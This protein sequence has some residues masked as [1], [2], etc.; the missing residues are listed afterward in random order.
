M[1]SLVQRHA[2]QASELGIRCAS[3]RL[4]SPA[5]LILL[6]DEWVTSSG[7]VSLSAGWVLGLGSHLGDHDVAVGEDGDE[8]DGDDSGDNGD[9]EEE[10]M[11]MKMKVRMRGVMMRRMLVMVV[12][13]KYRLD[14]LIVQSKCG[15]SG[16]TLLNVP[17]LQ[18]APG[19]V[20]SGVVS[21]H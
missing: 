1:S 10:V 16:K 19:S 2:V 17:V 11:M 20:V 7:S 5:L 12:P 3:F 14:G 21:V 4:S 13:M 18:Q 15:S 9:E 8:G 6:G